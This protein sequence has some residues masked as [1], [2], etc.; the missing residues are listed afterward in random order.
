MPP[1]GCPSRR[2]QLVAGAGHSP[3]VEKPAGTAAL[4]LAIRVA[5]ART[6]GTNCK[7]ACRN[8]RRPKPPLNCEPMF[9][10][11]TTLTGAADR[12][13]RPADRLRHARRVRPGARWETA[14][15]VNPVAARTHRAPGPRLAGPP[16]G[17]VAPPSAPDSGQRH[18]RS[19]AVGTAIIA[20]LLVVGA[21]ISWHFSSAV[22]VPDR[23]DWPEDV[24]VEAV[25]PGR[26]VLS[27]SDDSLKPGSYG[28]DWQAGHAVVGRSS[29]ATRTPSRAA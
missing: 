9:D 18:R 24:T 19:I 11:K 15:A 17:P 13:R 8:R 27:R 12:R 7:K 14:P 29:P 23:S 3:N 5:E 26:I 4:V 10:S 22:V 1:T 16:V 28:L 20:V 21:A 25:E 6:A 2:P